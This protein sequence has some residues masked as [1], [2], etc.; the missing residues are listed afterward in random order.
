[1]IL[2]EVPPAMPEPPQ[3]RA[4]QPRAV[5]L[6]P[7]TIPLTPLLNVRTFSTCISVQVALSAAT[8]LPSHPRAVP[9]RMVAFVRPLT[10]RTP[11]VTPL[12]GP[13][14]SKPPRSSVTLSALIVMPLWPATP[15]RLPVTKYDPGW[16]MV[17]GRAEIG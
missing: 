12:P 17:N 2:Q 5:P 11:F 13:T 14:S 16:V 10:T 7:R 8:L 3:E 6:L 4:T 9:L 15:V 1:M